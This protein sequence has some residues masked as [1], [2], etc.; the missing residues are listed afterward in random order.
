MTPIQNWLISI[1][2]CQKIP[3]QA[4]RDIWG[5]EHMMVRSDLMDINF[6]YRKV[7]MTDAFH[8]KHRTVADQLFTGLFTHVWGE[9]AEYNTVVW[10]MYGRGN[11]G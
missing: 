3:K 2:C 10:K 9:K 5:T 11:R 4:I 6:G 8:K 1:G 7:S